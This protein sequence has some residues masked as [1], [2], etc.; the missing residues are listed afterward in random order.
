LLHR[1]EEVISLEERVARAIFASNQHADM[2]A[3]YAAW[4]QVLATSQQL[5]HQM[6]CVQ[7]PN[8]GGHY[9]RVQVPPGYD[10]F[11]AQPQSSV[12]QENPYGLGGNGPAWGPRQSAIQP[13]FRLDSINYG[14]YPDSAPRV[15]IGE[16]V[17]GALLNR[18]LNR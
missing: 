10:Y 18:F 7:T 4:Q 8:F 14:P 16:I 6:Q 3:F 12:Q 2:P 11:P 17:I 15:D 13:S 5:R 1:W 9:G